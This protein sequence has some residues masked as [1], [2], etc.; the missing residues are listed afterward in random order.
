MDRDGKSFGRSPLLGLALAIAICSSTATV[1]PCT[2]FVL[3]DK[4]RALF[5]NNEDHPNPKT[6]IWFQPAGEGYLGAVY[7]GVET[8]WAQG[9]LNTEGLAFDWVAGYKEDWQQ[10]A[11]V[12]RVRGNPSQRMLETCARVHDAIAFFRTH[13]DP[14]FSYARILVADRTGAS[15]VIS[16]KD[17][18]LKVDEENQS[19]GFGFGARTLDVALARRP[20]PVV[21]E[22]FKILRACRQGGYYTTKYSNIFDLRSGD[23]FLSYLPNRDDQVRLNLA[24]ELRKGAH[25][26]EVPEIRRELVQT[27][28]PLPLTMRRFPLDL[29]KP[30]PDPESNLTAH[31][32]DLIHE[33]AQG[34][35]HAEDF[36]PEMWKRISALPKGS[37]E[38]LKRFGGLNSM[39][40]VERNEEDGQRIYYYRSEYANAT[41]LQQIVLDAENRVASGNLWVDVKWKRDTSGAIR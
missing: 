7:V 31:L 22:G 33:S 2:I 15:A 12:P 41:V 14:A 18:K 5:C 23:I 24:A 11:H 9:G 6:R 8:G 34:T 4:S 28:R 35:S 1:H 16:A 10:D 38:D 19:R 3:A 13:W 40:L 30:L 21:A 26:Y 17:G 20:N 25:Y 29:V 37:Q 27:V 32:R 36:T 39:T